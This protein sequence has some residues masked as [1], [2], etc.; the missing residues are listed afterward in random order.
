MTIPITRQIQEQ[1][2]TLS[3]AERRV[4]DW[5]L[6]H[7]AEAIDG[8]IAEVAKAAEVSEPTVIRF[9]RRFGLSGFRDLRVQLITAQQRPDSYVHRDVASTDSGK[10]AVTK[11]ID[12][13][14]RALVEVRELIETMPFEAAAAALAAAR[15]II[16]VGTGASGIVAQDARHKFFR[17]GVA[18]SVAIDPQTILQQ[19]AVLD[20]RDVVI[21]ISHTGEWPELIAAMAIAHS[22]GARVIALTDPDSRLARAADFAFACH[23]Q[24]DTSIFT[25]MTSRLAQLL[26][27]DALQVALALEMG[28]DAQSHLR[29]SKE[30]LANYRSNW[31]VDGGEIPGGKASHGRERP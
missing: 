10:V 24:E 6:S 12:S 25:P 20:A 7:V 19:A 4:G 13:S 2:P 17:L 31:T 23:P 30:T 5:L 29:H 21:A 14:I 11:V 22:R 3:P 1:L 15:Q 26:L 9:C 28:D 16:F 27:L 18:C 8:S